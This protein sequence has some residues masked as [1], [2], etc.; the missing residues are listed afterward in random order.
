M[1][2]SS[3]YFGFG[4]E[5][6]RV[7]C[8]RNCNLNWNLEFQSAYLISLIVDC[9]SKHIRTRACMFIVVAIGT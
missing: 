9:I 3:A 1:Y 8:D 7:I 5:D 4:D 6:M 2:P